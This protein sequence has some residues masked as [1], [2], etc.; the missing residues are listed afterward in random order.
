[1][2]TMKHLMHDIC[3]AFMYIEDT[4]IVPDSLKWIE[5]AKRANGEQFRMTGFGEAKF[6]LKMD[7]VRNKDGTV[8]LSQ[9]QYTQEILEKCIMLDNTPSNVPMAPTIR[10]GEVASDHDKAALT[11][12]EHDTFRA[13]LGS[14]NFLCI[15][16]P[17]DIAFAIIVI[18]MRQ[19][20]PTQLHLKQLKRILRYLNGTRSM[21][22]TY[23]RASQD[24]AYDIKVVS[25]SYWATDT[26]TRR[27]KS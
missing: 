15:C 13:I 22:I 2:H 1:M 26:T 4:L 19:T 3:I 9:E 24:N 12:P 10:D 11:P 27:C 6:M 21:G 14:V 25:D 18:N 20:V 16:T 5:S 23:G 8:S 7:M 17:P